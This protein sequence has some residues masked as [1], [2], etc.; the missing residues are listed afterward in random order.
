MTESQPAIPQNETIMCPEQRIPS[1]DETVDISQPAHVLVHGAWHTSAHWQPL[2]TELQLSGA[3]VVT[4][5]LPASN[6]DATFDDDTDVVAK[7]LEDLDN[8]VLTV[9]SRG[10]ETV[11]RL[12]QRTSMLKVIRGVVIINSGGPHDL[13]LP[14]SCNDLPRYS[15]LFHTGVRPLNDRLTVFDKAIAREVFYHDVEDAIALE[16]AA[17]LRPQ[18]L[19]VRGQS[20]LPQMPRHIPITYMQGIDDRVLNVARVEAVAAHWLGVKL[21][22]LQGGHSPQLAQ[23]KQLAAKLR[24]FAGIVSSMNYATGAGK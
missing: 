18:R 17:M 5:D 22:Q 6:P 11:P 2:K 24:E 23:P 7:S 21:V 8:V 9:H 13:K 10:V 16:A 4:P 1:S 12:L 14:P 20:P 15:T 3:E 19:P